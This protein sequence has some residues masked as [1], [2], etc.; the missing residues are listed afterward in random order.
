MKKLFM[1]TALLYTG[2]LNAA[3][4][5]DDVGRTVNVHTPVYSVVCLSPAHTEMFFWMGLQDKLRAVSTSCDFPDA[6][7]KLPKA[8]SFM[9]PDIEKI[10]KLRPDVV[11][12]GGGV[13]K[14]AIAKLEKMG[15]PVLV[16]YPKNIEKG[17]WDN[18]NMIGRLTGEPVKASKKIRE[19]EK[20]MSEVIRRD[21][22]Q[23]KVY[24]EMWNEPVMAVG[25]SSFINQMLKLGGGKNILADAKSEYPKASPEE[26]IKRNPDVII[27]LYKPEKDYMDRPYF[28]QTNAGKKGNIYV[29][30]NVDIILRP[31]PRIPLGIKSLRKIIDKA[32]SKT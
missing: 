32:E 7:K 25:K 20:T 3:V 27:L 31:G 10:T 30:D 24:L 1:I 21:S 11:I 12:S 2:F 29:F 28:K 14:K 13:Q 5:V 22:F 23:L 8:G 18:I 6:A 16:L 15:I 26:I 9:N 19:Y 17:I 4:F